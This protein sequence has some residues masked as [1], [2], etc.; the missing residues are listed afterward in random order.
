M[1][2]LFK[3]SLVALISLLFAGEMKAQLNESFTDA[4]FP[5]T[6]WT[7]ATYQ[8]AGGNWLR[9]TTSFRTTPA[10]AISNF[11]NPNGENILRT[12]QFTPITNDSLI[13]WF[14]QSFGT[15]YADTMKIMVSTTDTAKASFTTILTLADGVNYPPSG[16][17]GRFAVSLGAYSG[18]PI[19]VAFTQRW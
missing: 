15:V 18:T 16:T 4:T 14:R 17:Y 6:G 12:L 10:C 7:S 9:S 19:Y 1:K 2:K 3:L 13:F 5:P 8:G 11:Q